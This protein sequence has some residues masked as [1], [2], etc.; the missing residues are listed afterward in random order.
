MVWQ[1]MRLQLAED[2]PCGFG[3]LAGPHT[4]TTISAH[5]GQSP[6]PLHENATKNCPRHV[7]QRTRAKPCQATVRHYANGRHGPMRSATATTKSKAAH[8]AGNQRETR[9]GAALG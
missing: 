7:P 4:S 9:V 2:M 8:M 5:E 1:T 3:P 6:R